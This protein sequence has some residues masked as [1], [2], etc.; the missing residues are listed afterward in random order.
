[1]R[2][3]DHFDAPATVE[4][5]NVPKAE[6]ESE[7]WRLPGKK[8]RVEREA[9]RRQSQEIPKRS[10]PTDPSNNGDEHVD[11]DRS[12]EQN[13][14]A[15]QI[16]VSTDADW[17]RSRTSRLLGLED[18]EDHQNE[19]KVGVDQA[20]PLGASENESPVAQT[21]RHGDQMEPIQ[22]TEPNPGEDHPK[23]APSDRDI[24]IIQKTARLFVRNL[25]YS[26]AED[27]LQQQFAQIGQIEEVR[28]TDS[29]F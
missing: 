27:D 17:L 5:N 29:L 25:S 4:S 11:S 7:Y 23:I 14:P 9:G 28:H 21:T 2:N 8:G 22:V 10:Q 3:N 15:R 12:K 24:D 26:V 20:T 1:M 6:S 19:G 18:D 16:V 13:S